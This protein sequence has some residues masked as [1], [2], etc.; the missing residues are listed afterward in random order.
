MHWGVAAAAIVAWRLAMLPPRRS[1]ALT[2][3]VELNLPTG[4]GSAPY[5]MLRG[6]VSLDTA[7]AF[8]LRM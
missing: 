8:T 1:A 6:E 7:A 5:Q 3:S 4:M 2:P